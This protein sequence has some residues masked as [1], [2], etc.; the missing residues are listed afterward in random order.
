[1]IGRSVPSRF[2]ACLATTAFLVIAPC[3][4]VAAQVVTHAIEIGGV[5]CGYS[6]ARASAIDGADCTKV[7]QVV[8]AKVSLLGSG[9][10]I[11]IDTTF[12]VD[13]KTQQFRSLQ[14]HVRKGDTESAVQAV[15]EGDQVRIVYP[16]EGTE[17]IV[18]L[19]SD[20]IL[21]NPMGSPHL[22]RDF[23]DGE[24]ESATYHVFAVHEARVKEVQFKRVG[25]E[26]IE[27]AGVA[28]DVVVLDSFEESTGVNTRQWLDRDSGMTVKLNLPGGRDIYLADASV[29]TRVQMAD[30]DSSILAKTNVAIADVQAI[31]FMKVKAVLEPTGLRLDADALNVPGQRFEGRVEGN[32]VDGVFTVEHVRYDGSLAPPFPRDPQADESLA[33]FLAADRY[34]QSDDPVLIA[35][36]RQLTGDATDSWD[37]ACRLSR[38]VAEN[39]DYAIPGGGDARKTFDTRAG[40]CGAHSMLLAALCRAVGIPARVVWGCMYVPNAGGAFGQHGWTEVHMGAAG[41]IPVDATAMEFDFVDSG[42]I[43]VGHFQSAATAVNLQEMEVLEHRL[44]TSSEQVDDGVAAR[45]DAFVADYASPSETRTFGIVR[46]GGE[47]VLVTPDR[48]SLVLRDP[49]AEGHWHAKLADHVY[50][51]FV[52]D[53]RGGIVGLSIHEVLRMRRLEDVAASVDAPATIRPFLGRYRLAAIRA[54][55]EV[56]C[57]GGGMQVRYPN[58]DV[59]VAFEALGSG[60]FVDASG[61]QVVWFERDGAGT[62]AT[63]FLDSGTR[64]DRQVPEHPEVAAVKTMLIDF[65]GAAA[66]ADVDRMFSLLAADAVVIGT[67]ATERWTVAEFRALVEPS[68][69]QGKGWTTTPTEQNVYLA[70]DGTIAWFDERLKSSR[71]GEMRGTGVARKTGAGWQIVHYSNAFPVPN[72]LV[73]ALVEQ[74]EERSRAK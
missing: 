62:V 37:A 18:A 8:F 32:R 19:P 50:C 10:D 42:H 30:L 27:L 25:R 3:A 36:A 70:A 57:E 73:P 33:A 20:V 13:P 45:L 12:E 44:I 64:F 26:T 21:E 2:R 54:D 61:K 22:I 34:C 40:E 39:I 14:A 11:R 55:F 15:V 23:V 31:R 72:E 58:N 60:R 49:D 59:G 53:E 6:E 28:H 16:M 4:R 48:V 69:T 74:I 67:D 63:M 9:F 46:R 1:M 66:T 56:R 7:T 38:W 47:L 51:E 68:F 52:R 29:K 41:W 65:H 43:R 35:H 5:L 17:K 71:F 24:L